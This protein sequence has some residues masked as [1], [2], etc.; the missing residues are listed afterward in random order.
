MKIVHIQ[1]SRLS[2][3]VGTTRQAAPDEATCRN[4]AR[5]GC[6]MCGEVLYYGNDAARI[7]R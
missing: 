6:G 5:T 4:G 2:E 3:P 1:S 7:V